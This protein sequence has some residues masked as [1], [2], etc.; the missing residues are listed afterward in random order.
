MMFDFIA[1]MIYSAIFCFASLGT[2]LYTFAY[3]QM[4]KTRII[5]SLAYFLFTVSLDTCW[6]MI[7][8]Y[9]R[10][11]SNDANYEAWMVSPIILVLTKSIL[12]SGVMIFVINSVREDKSA[13]RTCAGLL[14]HRRNEKDG[15]V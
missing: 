13:L 2:A 12:L 9:R 4:K 7:T 1:V 11:V 8:E 10:F 3:L 14:K 5:G 6:W 15:M